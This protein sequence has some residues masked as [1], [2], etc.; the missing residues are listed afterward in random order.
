L[1]TYGRRQSLLD[2]KQQPKFARSELA[3]T[4]EVSEG[5]IRNDLNALELEGRLK[6]CMG[7]SF[8]QSGS[9]PK[10]FLFA[11]LFNKIQVENFLLRE[12]AH[13]Y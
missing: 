9:I 2:A 1:N 11:S 10:Q 8:E 13:I 5:T 7:S 4:L 3:K 12:G 6:M